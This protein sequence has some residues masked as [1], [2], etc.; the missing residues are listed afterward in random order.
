M[1]MCQKVVHHVSIGTCVYIFKTR[2]G[3]SYMYLITHLQQ[4]GIYH[5]AIYLRNWNLHPITDKSIVILITLFVFIKLQVN[6][7]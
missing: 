2:V 7:F 1:E 3:H 5:G 6:Y 4:K